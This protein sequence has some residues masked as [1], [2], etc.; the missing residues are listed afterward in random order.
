MVYPNPSDGRFKITLPD[1]MV[2][3]LC[4][5]QVFNA[6]GEI[7]HTESRRCDQGGNTLDIAIEGLQTGIYFLKFNSGYK[8]YI[9]K[10]IV[11]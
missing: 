9:D 4:S 11:R 6:L 8:I 3:P 1:G 5:L 2:H 10:L 7:V